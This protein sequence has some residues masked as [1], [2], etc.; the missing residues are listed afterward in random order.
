MVEIL[1]I[2]GKIILEVRNRCAP[3]PMTQ[4]GKEPSQYFFVFT[5]RDHLDATVSKVTHPTCDL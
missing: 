3:W 1:I 2:I 5:I 4:P